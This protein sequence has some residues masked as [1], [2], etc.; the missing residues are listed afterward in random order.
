[1]IFRVFRVRQSFGQPEALLHQT[2]GFTTRISA[3][4]IEQQIFQQLF[5]GRTINRRNPFIKAGFQ[6][7]VELTQQNLRTFWQAVL[8]QQPLTEC[9]S[10]QPDNPLGSTTHGLIELSEE[11]IN[12]VFRQIRIA[13]LQQLESRRLQHLTRFAQPW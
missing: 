4:N 7:L 9:Q 11:F 3:G 13:I 8:F 1:M 6:K 10:R 5:S 12:V 2:N